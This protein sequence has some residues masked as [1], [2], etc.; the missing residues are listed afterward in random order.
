MAAKE[1][2]SPN[3]SEWDLLF[4]LWELKR[5]SAREVAER[6]ADSRG[7][8]YS[9]VK[10]LLDRMAAKGMVTVRQVGNVHE[11]TPA[12]EPQAAQRSAWR[13]FVD[14]AFRGATAPALEF[15][16][17]DARLTTEQR[18]TL[19]SLLNEDESALPGSEGLR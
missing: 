19:K 1:Q 14:A 9:T 16:A 5:A 2:R 10:T 17:T 7:W 18:E 15:I 11:Y 6:L 12:L 3:D 4:A 8:A 13:R